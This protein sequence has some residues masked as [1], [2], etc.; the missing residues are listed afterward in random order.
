MRIAY[1][2]QKGIPA[3]YGG[4]ERHVEEL[5]TRIA[6][7]GHN[8]CVYCREHYVRKHE[9]FKHTETL[10]KTYKNINLIFIPSFITSSTEKIGIDTITH[11]FLS[12]IHS[13]FKNYD[14]IH[15]HG[16][17][18]SSFSILPKILKP[19]AR[20]V[21][22]FHSKDYEHQKW[23]PIAR[24][25]LR[26]GEYL[27]VHIPHGT[28]CVSK[29]Y[30]EYV[31]KKYHKEI[32]YI[33]NG[34]PIY[35]KEPESIIQQWG[36]TKDN[37]LLAV[38][39]LVRHKGMHFLVEAYL[40]LK[41]NKKLVIV[42]ESAFTDHY[43]TALKIAARSSPNIIFTGNQTDQALAELFS[44]CYT[45]IH[46]SL[47]E[48]LPIVILEAMSYGKCVLASNIPENL[49]AIAE[50]GY[51]FKAG[52]VKDLARKLK[53]LLA[54]PDLVTQIGE[55]ARL[56]VLKEYNWDKI[57]QKTEEFYEGLFAYHPAN[58]HPVSLKGQN[59]DQATLETEKFYH[60]LL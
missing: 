31:R 55:R 46:P 4:I 34:V 7:R 11:S 56:R 45:F 19:S 8:V 29:S 53:G 14:I 41:T 54:R 52:D 35:E 3:T 36:L 18:P 38:S 57:T 10:P 1:I 44:N 43:V 42:G 2:G 16:I 6:K 25:L 12:S 30:Q 22:T 21:A 5:A 40:K 32:E 26:I 24:G 48:G 17:G 47:S 13:L 23:G 33:P 9:D 28:I 60:S 20:V 49:E 51:S 27:T 58:L 39:R 15:Y 59:W 50:S 37:Y